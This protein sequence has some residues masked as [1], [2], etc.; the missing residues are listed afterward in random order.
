MIKV[1]DLVCRGLAD[2]EV[3][4][5]KLSSA[6]N[7][8]VKHCASILA[9]LNFLAS[10]NVGEDKAKLYSAL[11]MQL[12][13]GLALLGDVELKNVAIIAN[14]IV[15]KLCQKFGVTRKDYDYSSIVNGYDKYFESKQEAEVVVK[16]I[17]K[18]A[19]KTIK[20]A[21]IQKGIDK[22]IIQT[23]KKQLAALEKSYT[24][25]KRGVD[26]NRLQQLYTYYEQI[27]AD[28]VLSQD[29]KKSTIHKPGTDNYVAYSSADKLISVRN[30]ILADIATVFASQAKNVSGTVTLLNKYCDAKFG[31]TAKNYIK[32]QVALLIDYLPKQ[33][34]EMIQK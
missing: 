1:I 11:S 12:C 16:P 2:A 19:D 30:D 17:I 10:I 9:S 6:N 15:D 31:K 28:Y 27:I 8:A 32:E 3:K 25:R 29:G 4:S 18:K 7:D 14:G 13:N 5:K 26:F 22:I 21:T 23:L 34:D 33:Q 20:P 24:T